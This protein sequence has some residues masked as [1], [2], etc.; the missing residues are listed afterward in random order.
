[1]LVLSGVLGDLQQ[2]RLEDLMHKRKTSLIQEPTNSTLTF[3][4]LLEFVFR[5]NNSAFEFINKVKLCCLL[6]LTTQ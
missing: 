2:S 3:S 4:Q 5:A 6:H 1:M